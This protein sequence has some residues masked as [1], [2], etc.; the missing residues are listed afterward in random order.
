MGRRGWRI[1][2]GV[3]AVL[4]ALL[5]SAGG[6]IALNA[7][8]IAA[9]V[10]E[11]K[12]PEWSERLGREVTLERVDIHVFPWPRAE[13]IQLQVAGAPGEPVLL[14]S[15]RA[16]LSLRLWPLLSSFGREV[17]IRAV[18]LQGTELTLVRRGEGQWSYQDLMK[19]APAGERG[20]ARSIE[21]ARV[22]IEDARLTIVD[23]ARR[24]TLTHID[25]TASNIEDRKPFDVRLRAAFASE[26]QNLAATL[27]VDPAD[28]PTGA[29]AFEG[30]VSLDRADLGTLQ[31]LLPAKHEALVKQGTLSLTSYVS[32]RSQTPDSPIH[33]D[34]RQL[35]IEGPGVRL[36]GSARV[37]TEPLNVTFA[38]T[39]ERLD[40]DQLLGRRSDEAHAPRGRA[41][42]A[43]ARKKLGAASVSG[44]LSLDEVRRGKLVFTQLDARTTL[45]EGVLRLDQ[46]TARLF[47]GQVELSGTTVDL[48]APLPAW[49]MRARA[50]SIDLGQ[51]MQA[52]T[53]HRPIDGRAT[54]GLDLSGAGTDWSAIRD[55]VTGSGSFLIEQGALRMGVNEQVL[56]AI[57][58]AA[59]VLEKPGAAERTE[60]LATTELRDVGGQFRIEQGWLQL[61][62]PLRVS[63]PAGEASLGGRISLAR[64]LDL[65]G[66]LA[67]SPA[68]VSSATGGQ[69]VPRRPV[70][71]PL[72]VRGAVTEPQ[73][74]IALS[75]AELGRALL[76]A[77]GSDEVE[78]LKDKA[79]RE[80]Q[81]RFKNLLD[82]AR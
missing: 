73:V 6:V 22:E 2:L 34:I 16:E 7:D 64:E 40:L 33:L 18:E 13:L 39:G 61:S 52:F 43:R 4:A 76:G 67:L 68:V 69:L 24:V 49:R 59:A 15:P 29:L 54:V 10:T 36:G 30:D 51:A 12:L 81:G 41:G 8:R 38:L 42:A 50:Q 25:G 56:G 35:A 45:S 74:E 14:Q 65:R 82:R 79:R 17:Q 26:R 80:V 57:R 19:R 55:K 1:A 5:V 3:A 31:G 53:A 72:V 62:R 9:A 32:K 23:R 46:A 21:I 20:A 48:T 44:T 66:E 63:L 75:A 11:R 27:R 60:A 37:R 77:P 70:P 78:A 71:V 58:Q 47:G 28:N